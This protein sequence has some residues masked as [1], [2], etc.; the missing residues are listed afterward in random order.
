MTAARLRPLLTVV[1]LAGAFV[2]W[3]VLS[4]G[5]E[6]YF[7]PPLS[8]ILDTFL[9][10]WVFERVAEDMLPSLAR[11]LGGLAIATVLGVAGGLLLGSV[12]PVR[13]ACEPIIEFM[14]AMP[15]PAL[16]P[17]ALLAFGIGD[18]MKVFLIATGCIWPVLL[19][20]IEGARVLD[21][22]LRDTALSF[23]MTRKDRMLLAI[24][25]T[26]APYV[27]A[28]LRTSVPLAQIMMVI[29]EMVASTDGIG[30]SV[31]QG[32]RQFAYAEMWAGIL[33]LAL[34]GVILNGGL[35]LLERLVFRSRWPSG[36][37]VTS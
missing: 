7:L 1:V 6:V 34:L 2:L 28:G 5:S 33:L 14:R 18:G 20:T 13:R 4:A 35:T 16:I 24:L 30:Y 10:T 17:F 21:P 9:D 8:E 31:L 27:F 25:P 12:P 22:L 36:S 26:A 11:M 23:R 15:P 32:Q 37:S 3:W 19:N 29:S